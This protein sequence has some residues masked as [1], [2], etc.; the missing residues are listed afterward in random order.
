MKLTAKQLRKLVESVI[1]E[2][3]PYVGNEIYEAD[4]SDMIEFARAWSKLGWAIQEQVIEFIDAGGE[5]DGIDINP[6][7]VDEA[8]NA[9]QGFNASIDD[10]FDRFDEWFG[11]P[12]PGDED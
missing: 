1:N 5:M 9:L 4:P 6:N 11:N 3:T 8:K 12:G 10:M 7:A 2:G